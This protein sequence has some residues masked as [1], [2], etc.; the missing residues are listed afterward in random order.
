M[1]RISKAF[2]AVA[3]AGAMIV[4]T[5]GAAQA[6]DEP[7]RPA[8]VPDGRFYIGCQGHVHWDA[9]NDDYWPWYCT[10]NNQSMSNSGYPGGRDKVNVYWG[11]NYSGAYACM[12]P[13]YSWNAYFSPGMY[14][15]FFWTRNGDRRGIDQSVWNNAV[16]HRWV[17][18]C[19]YNSW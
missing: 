1:G 10:N 6:G 16:S 15:T 9:G 8:S 7:D 14:Q 3:I 11:G 13:G 5:P 12:R 4:A 2:V 18:Y 17:T 19:G